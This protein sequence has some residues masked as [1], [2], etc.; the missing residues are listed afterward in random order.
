V[1]KLITAK[2]NIP[3]ISTR[4]IERIDLLAQLEESLAYKLVLLSTPAGFGKTTLLYQWAMAHPNRCSW[5][6]LDETDNNPV[7]FWQY[8]EAALHHLLP[9]YFNSFNDWH[10]F[11]ESLSNLINCLSERATPLNLIVDD[12]QTITNPQIHSSLAFF[13]ENLPPI[14]ATNL[15]RVR[16]RMRLVARIGSELAINHGNSVAGLLL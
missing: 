6:S 3:T 9:T 11:D 5:L 13:I 12:Y 15:I 10:K 1:N 2:I 8:F 4:I 14:L 16:T 7:Q